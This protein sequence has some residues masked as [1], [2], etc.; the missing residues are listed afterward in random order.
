MSDVRAMGQRATQV[1]E[2][3]VGLV[4]DRVATRLA[5]EIFRQPATLD[6]E[7]RYD[8]VEYRSLVIAVVDVLQKV[9]GADGRFVGE[10]LD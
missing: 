3:V 7:I 1:L 8:T 4:F 6:H 10:K 5:A 2:P 9:L